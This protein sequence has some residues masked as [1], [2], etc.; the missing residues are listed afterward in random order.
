M[1]LLR[2]HLPR[3]FYNKNAIGSYRIK[4][5]ELDTNILGVICFSMIHSVLPFE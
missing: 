3:E 2:L 5:I 4:R 1:K